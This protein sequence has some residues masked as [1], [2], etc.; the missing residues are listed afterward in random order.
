M[1]INKMILSL[2]LT[3]QDGVRVC[4]ELVRAIVFIFLI[5][6]TA[7]EGTA[8]IMISPPVASTATVIIHYTHVSLK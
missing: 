2:K 3:D 5:N 7:K 4:I 8:Y 6:I 1:L